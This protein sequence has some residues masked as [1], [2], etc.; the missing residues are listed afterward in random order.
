MYVVHLQ[1]MYILIYF[2]NSYPILVDSICKDNPHG[3]DVLNPA[4][5]YIPPESV[6]LYLT[7]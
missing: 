3:V 4:L 6:S 7:N 2:A 1:L 5:D